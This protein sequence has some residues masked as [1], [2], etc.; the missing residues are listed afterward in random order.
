MSYISSIQPTQ[1][2]GANAL[3]YNYTTDTVEIGTE[4][5]V[6]PTVT[7]DG[8]IEMEIEPVLSSFLGMPSFTVPAQPGTG[9]TTSQIEIGEPNVAERTATVSVRVKDGETIVIGGLITDRYTDEDYT[10]PWLGRIPG[11]EIFFNDYDRQRDLDTLLIFVTAHI[12]K[13]G[14]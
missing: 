14:L 11:V 5:N 9:G 12:V 13:E 6:T 10:T 1:I 2:Q 8:Y 3:A 4:L 7:G